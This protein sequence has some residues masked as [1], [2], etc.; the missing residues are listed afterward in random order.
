MDF[1]LPELRQPSYRALTRA[2]ATGTLVAAAVAVVALQL[3]T[4]G[5]NLPPTTIALV[6]LPLSMPG[7][8]WLTR[9]VL[10]RRT[11]YVLPWWTAAVGVVTSWVATPWAG[12]WLLREVL[13]GTFGGEETEP[14]AAAPAPAA[15]AP[16]QL[17]FQT[18]LDAMPPPL[19]VAAPRV[20]A[21]VEEEP[22]APLRLV[23]APPV[24]DAVLPAL[25]EPTPAE[26]LL[27]ADPPLPETVVAAF[28]LPPAPVAAPEPVAAFPLPEP[29]APVY[30]A[31]PEP[32]PVAAPTEPALAEAA[33]VVV[34][35]VAPPQ[36]LPPLEEADMAFFLP[37]SELET[38][39]VHDPFATFW[40]DP[41]APP[42]EGLTPG[43]L[44]PLAGM[45][46][47]PLGDTL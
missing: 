20:E 2:L 36:A 25:D 46:H 11:G 35:H 5:E 33:P 22:F 15:A 21:P 1:V 6:A 31:D 18:G 41:G 32:A 9:I 14:P 29:A 27:P 26:P 4:L 17:D 39:A 40:L 30:E 42:P 13:A 7:A 23:A 3:A 19:P 47:T 38:A 16:A 12:A 24:V 43:Y 8:I 45:W 34:D 28:P 44:P 10:E 37:Q